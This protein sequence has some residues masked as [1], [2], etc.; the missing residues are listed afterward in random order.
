MVYDMRGRALKLYGTM[1]G[2]AM[3]VYGIQWEGN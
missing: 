2:R 3:K 1:R